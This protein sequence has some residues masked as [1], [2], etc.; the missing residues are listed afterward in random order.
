MAVPLGSRNSRLKAGAGRCVEALLDRE[1]SLLPVCEPSTG[2]TE[3]RES[4]FGGIVAPGLLLLLALVFPKSFSCSGSSNELLVRADSR[5]AA[6]LAAATAPATDVAAGG[7]AAVL[8]TG[9]AGG[10]LDSGRA[11]GP[12]ERFGAVGER[13]LPGGLPR[14]PL[15]ERSAAGRFSGDALR[16]PHTV[17]NAMCALETQWR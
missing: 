7:G 16:M 15:L 3:I 1:E 5:V 13:A 9:R 4:R 6:R 12:A 11:G 14:L 2:D 10:F 17:L 8:T